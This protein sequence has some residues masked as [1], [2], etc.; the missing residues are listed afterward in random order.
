MTLAFPEAR[1]AHTESINNS[2]T[3]KGVV[4]G[5]AVKNV[6]AETARQLVVVVAAEQGIVTDPADKIIISLTAG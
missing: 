4:V 5:I 6:I 3:S 1:Y 2:L